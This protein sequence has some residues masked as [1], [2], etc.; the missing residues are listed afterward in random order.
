MKMFGVKNEE[1][2]GDWRQLPSEVHKI[3]GEYATQE[4]I[5]E[6]CIGFC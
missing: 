6:V 5:R 1:V 3:D 4:G 2:I